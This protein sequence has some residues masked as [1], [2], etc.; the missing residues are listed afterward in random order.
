MKF[1]PFEEKIISSPEKIIN[2][3]NYIEVPA[4]NGRKPVEQEIEK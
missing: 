3:G 4:E 2:S 1:D